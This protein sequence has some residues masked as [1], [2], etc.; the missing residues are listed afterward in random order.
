MTKQ[1]LY[2]WRAV[3]LIGS[4]G[5]FWGVLALLVLQ[6]AWLACTGRYPMA[7][8]EDFHLGIIRLYAHHIS[9]FWNAQ[10]P[11]ADKFGA[12]FR[13][14][15]YLYQYLMSFPY[16][17]ISVFTA[18]QTIQ[19]LWLRAINIGLFKPALHRP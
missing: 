13:D 17:L 18:D 7:F 10:P 11:G 15:S 14:P 1:G 9:P 3:A 5:F 4:P 16:R 12:V 6:A 2:R 19:V 8:D